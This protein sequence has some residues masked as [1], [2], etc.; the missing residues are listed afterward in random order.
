[1]KTFNEICQ[2]LLAKHDHLNHP[3]PFRQTPANAGTHASHLQGNL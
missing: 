2:R 1:M 3:E